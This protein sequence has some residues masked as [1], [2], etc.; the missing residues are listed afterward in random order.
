VLPQK[1]VQLLVRDLPMTK[2]DLKDI[3]GIGKKKLQKF[4]QEIIDLITAYCI[5]NE[6]EIPD[7][8][9][10]ESVHI[11]AKIDSKKIS[12]ELFLGGKSPQKIALERQLTVSTV[13]G[14]LAYFVEQ[15]LL[16]LEK[17]VS[18]EKTEVIGAYL[19]Q[20]EEV[21]VGDAK[22]ALGDHFSYGEIRL[23]KAFLHS[24]ELS[25]P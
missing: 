8:R 12:L 15:G 18:P 19:M 5:Q 11:P 17:L 22:T 24:R 7:H 23:V 13:E 1:T 3:P 16:S 4:G 25:S 20:H 6:L 21:S 2:K 14:H 10:E 9:E